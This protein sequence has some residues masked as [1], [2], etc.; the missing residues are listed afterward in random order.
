MR[1]LLL[2]TLTGCGLGWIGGE[3]DRTAGLP[4]SGAGP[5]KALESDDL[6]PASEPRFVNDNRA[7]LSDPSMLGG[8]PGIRLWFTRSTDDPVASEIFYVEASSPHE[9]PTTPMLVLA[10]SE[11]WEE[12]LVGS[13]SV[14]PDPDGGLVMFYQGG[15]AMPSIGRAVSTDG[16]S[17]TK[18]PDPVLVGALGP[19]VV[20]AYGETWLF[21]TRPNETGIWRAVDAGS[22]FAFDAAP[23]IEPRPASRDAFD[24][25]TVADPFALAVPTLGPETRIHLWFSGSTDEPADAVAVGYA[26]SFDGITWER[27]GGEKPM[28][29]ADA[30]QPTVLLDAS[31]GLMLYRA[32]VASRFALNAAEH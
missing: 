1:A 25:L 8:G 9:L 19:S 12:G 24:R 20:F 16:L 14:M 21:A 4:T 30:A 18:D 7:N 17:W 5:Y 26:S 22:G 31:G 32:S 11:P 6:T 28:L 13:P 23:I 2:V 29:K 10:A 27:F 15:V 3:D